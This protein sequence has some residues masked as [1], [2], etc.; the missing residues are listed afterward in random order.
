MPD[1]RVM[2]LPDG[3]ELAWLETG[4]PRGFPVFTFH[5]T[6]GSR[7]QV[8]FDEK[9]ITA[10]GRPHASRRIGPGY[11]HSS[12]HPGRALADWAADVAAL[13]DHLKLESFAVVGRLGRWPPCRGLRRPAARA[14]GRRAGS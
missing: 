12:F 11:G 1:T 13:A 14:G 9:A 2:E 6:P 7:R 4:K 5:G 3:R 10:A 8:S